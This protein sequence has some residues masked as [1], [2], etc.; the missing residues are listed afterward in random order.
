MPFPVYSIPG[1]PKGRIMPAINTGGGGFSDLR[2]FLTA[3]TTY[4][5][6]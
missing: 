5:L 4:H 1:P 2:K 6:N 3:R